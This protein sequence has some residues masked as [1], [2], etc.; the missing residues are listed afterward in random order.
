MK[1]RLAALIGIFVTASA[2]FCSGERGSREYALA[3]ISHEGIKL[4]HDSEKISPCVLRAQRQWMQRP[5]IMVNSG[6]SFPPVTD[7]RHTGDGQFRLVFFSE[8]SPET[9]L[10]CFEDNASLGRSYRAFLFSGWR[11]SVL[12][13]INSRSAVQ[14]DRSTSCALRLARLSA[15]KRRPQTRAKGEENNNNRNNNRGRSGLALILRTVRWGSIPLVY[16][17]FY[18]WIRS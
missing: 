7:I 11:T 8:L 10:L 2:A 18:Y 13:H 15:D 12:S 16:F 5:F 6:Q 9:T 3:A 14:C 4:Q 1:I 17:C